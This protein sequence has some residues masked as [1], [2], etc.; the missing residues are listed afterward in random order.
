V[1]PLPDWIVA[2]VRGPER[3]AAVGPLM[4]GM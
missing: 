4:A 2:L 1:T 3:R